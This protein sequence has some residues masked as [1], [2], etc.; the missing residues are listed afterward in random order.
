VG[1]RP[2][3]SSRTRNGFDIAAD[4]FDDFPDC[5]VV[6]DASGEVFYLTSDNDKP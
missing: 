3:L 5:H 4:G 2:V 1:P 6:V